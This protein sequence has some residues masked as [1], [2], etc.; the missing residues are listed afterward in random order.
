MKP[1][2]SHLPLVSNFSIKVIP[3]IALRMSTAH[4]FR[5]INSRK[6]AR[7]PTERKSFPSN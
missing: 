7:A 5:V 2:K 3:S 6:W 4:G 1:S